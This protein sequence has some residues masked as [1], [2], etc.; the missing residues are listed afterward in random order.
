MQYI[1]KE[2][3]KTAKSLFLVIFFITNLF[4]SINASGA[5][6]KGTSAGKGIFEINLTLNPYGIISY[7]QDYVI[8]NYGLTDYMD[9]VTYYSSH[10]NGTK[11]AYWG[12]FYQFVDNNIIDLGTAFGARK[13]FNKQNGYDLF[14]PQLL[15]NFKLPKDYTIGGSIVSVYGKEEKYFNRGYTV[16]ITFYKPVKSIKRISKK[17]VDAHFG[18][19]VFKN[20]QMDFDLD[21]L[22]FQYSIDI[23]FNFKN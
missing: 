18:F 14:F 8:L 20:T 5:Y 10:Q 21:K 9:F 2:K 16:D 3:I 23:K 17:V 4:E 22:Y 1:F 15:Y 19:G 12:L 11:S 13:T 6:D 7:G